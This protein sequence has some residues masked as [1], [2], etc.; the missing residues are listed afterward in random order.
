M[1]TYSVYHFYISPDLNT[2]Y[3]G[4]S[5]DTNF[6]YKH[7]LSR[8]KKSNPILNNAFNVYGDSI[9]FQVIAKNLE[10]DAALLLEQML[11]PTSNIGWNQQPGGNIPPDPS[12]KSR[13]IEYRQNISRSKLGEKNPAWGTHPIFSK[14]HKQKISEAAKNAPIVQCQ[15][16][17]TVGRGNGMKRWHF[18]RCKYANVS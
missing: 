17:Q 3:V 6:R 16:C 4:V 9:K 13:S 14:I 7:H 10:L 1:N 15:H 18:D 8:K 11:R 12:G 2:G 5:K